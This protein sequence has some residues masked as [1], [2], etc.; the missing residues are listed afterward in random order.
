MPS[1][2]PETPDGSFFFHMM[3]GMGQ[4]EVDVLRQR[5]GDGMEAKLRAG[6]WAHKAPEGYMNKEK[7][8]KKGKYDRWVEQDPDQIQMIRDA[9]DLLLT[10]RYTL[11][12]ICEEL[13]LRGYIRSSGRPWSWNDPKDGVRR[14]A[15]NQLQRTFHNPFYA[16]W[17]TSKRFGIAYG[18]VRGNWDP[19]VTSQEFERGIAILHKHDQQ[20]SRQRR[21][22]Y[23][24]RNL[25]WIEVEGRHY[26]MYGST[27]SGKRQSYAYYRTH[28]K[29]RG[30]AIR[31]LCEMVEANIP[32]WLKNVVI[33]PENI[34]TIRKTYQAHVSQLTNC[35]RDS[36]IGQLQRR[37]AQL[38]EEEAHLAR[39][40]ITG[41]ISEETF[42]LLKLEWQDKLR[43]AE[44]TK[45]D[46]EQDAGRHLDDLD[47]GI[48]LL[49]RA[50]E[51]FSRLEIKD[52]SALLRILAKRIIVDEQGEIV[53][54]ELHS[55]FAYLSMLAGDKKRPKSNGM[56]SRWVTLGT[57]AVTRTRA[58]ASGGQRS[59]H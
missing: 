42:E 45:R 6:G 55:P 19:I 57:P 21:R 27:P 9:W 1:L 51:L 13:A 29:P 17:V 56:G 44:T 28:A 37:I 50:H 53:T 39:L 48:A 10:G 4:L 40:L 32:G 49:S 20:K 58:S 16:G 12:Q 14:Q 34:P 3:M 26:K 2:M 41:K 30:T 33:R 46:L 7:L 38:R 59:I 43:N 31:L 8:I 47:A 5:T 24:L 23:L 25:L 35:D 36:Q 54:H 15:K 52:R 22:F 11:A 18:E